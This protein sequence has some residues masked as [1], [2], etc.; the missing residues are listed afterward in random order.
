[1]DTMT[2]KP[3]PRVRPR[4]LCVD[5]EPQVLAAFCD[6]LRRHFDVVVAGGGREGAKAL[7]DSGPFTVVMSDFAMPGMN[8][9]QFLAQARL[10]APD[11]VRIL[12]TG[13]ASIEGAIAAVNEGNVFRFLTKPCSPDSLLRALEDAVEQA[14]LATRDRDLLEHKLEAMSG[15]LLRAERL[16]SLGTMAGAVGHELNNV[17]A[18]FVGAITFIREDAEAGKP[19]GEE[20]LRALDHVREHLTT[21]ARNLLQFGRRRQGGDRERAATDLRQAVADAVR[22]LQAAG[23]LRRAE[24]QLHLPSEDALVALDRTEVEQV[25]INVAKNA[26]E[27]VDEGTARPRID[28]TVER[29]PDGRSVVCAVRD[30]GRGVPKANLPFIFEP[31]F[32]TKPSDRGTGLG[33]FVVRRIVE[34]GGGR[35]SVSSDEGSGSLFTL[36][37]PVAARA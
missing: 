36:E 2:T 7:V 8:G 18:V 27:A 11:A 15:H 19:A 17:L 31:Y 4:I 23:L 29:S 16:A 37:L 35:V 32:T 5:D 28:I 1:M 21:H 26:V 24:I 22:L 33:L 14:R 10:L 30:N 34:G 25:L 20:D 12:L 9:A 3:Q 13:Q 6:T